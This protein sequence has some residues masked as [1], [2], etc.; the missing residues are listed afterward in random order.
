MEARAERMFA[1]IRNALRS[2]LLDVSRRNEMQNYETVAAAALTVIRHENVLN[3]H[4]L[5]RGD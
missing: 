1:H 5:L 3:V 2:C 4:C